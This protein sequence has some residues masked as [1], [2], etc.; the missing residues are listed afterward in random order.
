MGT[1]GNLALTF[2]LKNDILGNNLMRTQG[3]TSAS[4]GAPAGIDLG[5]ETLIL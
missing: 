1:L 3:N 2:E 4:K 5:V